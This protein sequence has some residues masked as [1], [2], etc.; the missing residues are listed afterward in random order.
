MSAQWLCAVEWQTKLWLNYSIAQGT[1]KTLSLYCKKP[2]YTY[3]SKFCMSVSECKDPVTR[4]VLAPHRCIIPRI[5]MIQGS[6]SLCI[7]LLAWAN[8][9]VETIKVST[10]F[11]YKNVNFVNIDRVNVAD[12]GKQWTLFGLLNNDKICIWQTQHNR[13]SISDVLLGGHQEIAHRL[14]ER[15][16]EGQSLSRDTTIFKNKNTNVD[17][18]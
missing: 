14:T 9:T 10:Q 4:A 5:W 16:R 13:C 18:L 2:I 11:L 12:S 6:Y 1:C 8:V 3:K 17:N 7:L 15:D